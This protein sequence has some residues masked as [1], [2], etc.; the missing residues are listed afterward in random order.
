MVNGIVNNVV[1]PG[2][3]GVF[4]GQMGVPVVE[5]DFPPLHAVLTIDL[6]RG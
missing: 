4:E 6:F 2:E 5:P 1:E 3:V